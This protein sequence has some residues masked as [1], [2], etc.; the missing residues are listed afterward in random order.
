[1]AK[2]VVTLRADIRS[3]LARSQN[4]PGFTNDNLNTIIGLGEQRLWQGLKDM[5]LEQVVTIARFTIGD[6]FIEKPANWYQT[7]NIVVGDENGVYQDSTILLKRDF[8]F[9]ITFNKNSSQSNAISPKPKYYCDRPKTANQ[10][11]QAYNFIFVSPTPAKQYY[12][13]IT[14]DAMPESL[15]VGGAGTNIYTVRFYNLLLYACLVEASNFV[16][17]SQETKGS[18]LQAYQGLLETALQQK[19]SRKT[20][21]NIDSSN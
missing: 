3:F 19:E 1:M 2:S 17:A 7:K 21:R 15:I 6:P 8:E 11:N 18:Y 20:D 10:S 16:K 14:Y 13:Q 4:D 5:A 12:Y 9:C